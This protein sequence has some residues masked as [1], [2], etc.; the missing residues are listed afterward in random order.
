MEKNQLVRQARIRAIVM[1][2][3]LGLALLSIIY[4]TIQHQ[5]ATAVERRQV[6]CEKQTVELTK[7]IES[8]DQQ[9][10]LALEEIRKTKEI[11]LLQASIAA[12]R[13]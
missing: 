12:K 8:K 4:G 1:G 9:L 10:M 5:L 3:A 13:K 2:T 7:Q 11:A 6:A